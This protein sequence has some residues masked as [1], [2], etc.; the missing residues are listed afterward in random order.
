M[1]GLY[2]VVLIISLFVWW[3]TNREKRAKGQSQPS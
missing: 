1:A 2:F 3:A